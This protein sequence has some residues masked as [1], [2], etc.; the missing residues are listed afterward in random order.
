MGEGGK[1]VRLQVERDKGGRNE[2]GLCSK[3]Y[4]G[5]ILFRS[6]RKWDLCYSMIST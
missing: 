2:K 5:T 1:G 6:F 3:M 4:S